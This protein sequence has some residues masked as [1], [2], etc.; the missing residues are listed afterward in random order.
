[1]EYEQAKET[2]LSICQKFKEELFQKDMISISDST[3]K[4]REPARI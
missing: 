2:Q 4:E 3:N 1:M